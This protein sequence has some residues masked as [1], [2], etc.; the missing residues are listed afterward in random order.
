MATFDPFPSLLLSV[1][2]NPV[3]SIG[4]P[5]AFGVLSGLPSTT[6]VQGQWYKSLEFPPGGRPSNRLFLTVWP[7]LYAGMGYASHLAVK[8]YDESLDSPTKEDAAYALKLY[9]IQ[10]GLNFAWSS[11]FFVA[12]KPGLALI[13]ITALTGTV[14]CLTKLMHGPTNGVSTYLLVPYCAWLGYTTYLNAGIWW[15]NRTRQ[16]PKI[17]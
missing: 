16:I 14:A 9:Y 11:L 3:T 5:L 4:L 10:L 17:D 6:A 8:A 12:K 7:F 1:S 13:D 15:K 2:R